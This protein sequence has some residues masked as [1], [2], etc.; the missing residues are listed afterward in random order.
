MSV[1]AGEVQAALQQEL[2]RWRQRHDELVGQFE[3]NAAEHAALEALLRRFIQRL[4]L[5]ARGLGDGLDRALDR[6]LEALRSPAPAEQL[7]PL[8]ELL[9]SAIADTD[10]PA[11]LGAQARAGAADGELRGTLARLVQRLEFDAS[12]Q[13]RAA[14]IRRRLESD[15]DMPAVLEACAGIS[16][17]VDAQRERLRLEQVDV[18]RILQQVDSRL[19]E[20]VTYLCGEQ[21]DREL[22]EQS[23]QQLDRGLLG[24]VRELSVQVDSATDLDLLRQQVGQRLEAVDRHLHGFRDRERERADQYRHRAERMRL[25]VE[26][27]E[28]E[29]R[30]LHASLQREQVNASTDFLTGIPNRLA[31]QQRVALEYKR[32]KRFGRPLSIAI[33]DIDCFKQVNDRHGHRAGDRAIRSIG[34]LLASQVRETDFVA[35]YGGE[36]FVA[37]LVDTP[38]DEARVAADKLRQAVAALRIDVDDAVLQLTVSCGIAEFRGG[39]STEAVFERADRALMAAKH[40]GRNRCVRDGERGTD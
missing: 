24:E 36:E 11:V 5:A 13:P 9:S 33:W 23:L 26:Q 7:A 15:A 14:E 39:D 2:G 31:L 21:Q 27:L 18:Q 38:A 22:A 28:R 29:A 19:G 6:V 20:F 8:L 32:W 3:Q 10:T 37:L 34:R 1:D 16:E 40:G 17:L 12:L 35:R 25:R 4:C 30:A